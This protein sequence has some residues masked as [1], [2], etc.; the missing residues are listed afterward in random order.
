MN[1][2]LLSCVRASWTIKELAGEMAGACV[3]TVKRAARRFQLAAD[4]PPDI[5]TGAKLWSHERACQLVK[6]WREYWIVRG[7]SPATANQKFCGACKD[8]SD[9]TKFN[10]HVIQTQK[11]EINFAEIYKARRRAD[12]GA[13]QT[14]KAKEK[15]GSS[16]TAARQRAGKRKRG[17]HA[18]NGARRL[19]A[20]PKATGASGN[21]L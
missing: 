3:R 18:G 20:R 15:A 4:L 13:G 11:P 5:Q 1:A 9:Q 16:S 2:P 8:D 6:L 7:Q 19:Q 12:S 10:F 17:K 14:P 21:L